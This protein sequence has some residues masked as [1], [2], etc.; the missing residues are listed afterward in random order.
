MKQNYLA[1]LGLSPALASIV[2]LIP[3]LCG[4]IMLP[5]FGAISDQCPATFFFFFSSGKRK[6]FIAGGALTLAAS[7]L[8]FAWSGDLARSLDGSCRPDRLHSCALAR[9]ISVLSILGMNVSVQALQA[10]VRALMV[11]VCGVEQ[12]SQVNAW[13]G[14]MVNAANVVYYGLA[15]MD[16]RRLLPFFGDTQLK[17]NCALCACIL[18]VTGGLTCSISTEETATRPSRWSGIRERFRDVISVLLSPDLLHIQAIQFLTWFAWFPYMMYIRSYLDGFGM[19]STPSTTVQYGSL[20][21]LFQSVIALLVITLLPPLASRITKRRSAGDNTS[22][23]DGNGF[24]WKTHRNIWAAAQVIF[25][26]AL[27]GITLTSSGIVRVILVGLTGTSW[28]VIQ[29]V[30]FT[31]MTVKIRA[32]STAAC[33][34]TY[35]E[36]SRN[37]GAMVGLFNLSI[38]IPQL[39]SMLLSS[40]IFSAMTDLLHGPAGCSRL[41]FFISSLMSFLGVVLTTRLKFM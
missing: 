36:D 10:G 33:Y 2:W 15:S 40:L 32:S 12:Q 24:D 19:K 31:F 5:V 16:L 25:A 34:L 29:W 23:A 11:D 28:A 27:L 20:A 37:V 21:L 8:V 30:P 26:S 6:P 14:R 1:S 18:L 39:V 13:A 3:P 7:L 9:D 22:T 35:K 4:G 17:V 41:I 38:V